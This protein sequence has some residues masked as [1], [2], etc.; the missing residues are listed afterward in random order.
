MPRKPLPPGER[1]R[2]VTVRIKE[3]DIEYIENNLGQKPGD[4]IYKATTEKVQKQRGAKE[5]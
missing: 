2:A 5:H 4:Y 1:R 3:K